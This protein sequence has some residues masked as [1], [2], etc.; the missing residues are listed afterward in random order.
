MCRLDDA[1]LLLADKPT[2][3]LSHEDRDHVIELIHE[4]GDDLGTTIVVVT[5]QPEV[6]ATFPR[7]SP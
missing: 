2:S 1:E 6:A 4:L 3:Q 5:H 7:T